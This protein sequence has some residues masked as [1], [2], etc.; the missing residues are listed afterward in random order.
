MKDPFPV[1]SHD[2]WRARVEA[3]LGGEDFERTLVTH[4]LEGL[5][6]QPLYSGESPTS[7]RTKLVDG[8]GFP[9]LWPFTRG[10]RAVPRG[11]R[12]WRISQLEDDPDPDGLRESIGADLWGGADAVW[13]R[14]DR[15]A[16]LGLDGDSEKAAEHTGWNGA[17]LYSAADLEAALAGADLAG[18]ALTFD[19]GANA[20]PAAALAVAAL[21]ASG[22][23]PEDL[24]LALGA[25]PLGALARD[26]EIPGPLPSLTEE[27]AVL[28]A[29]CH[30]RLPRSSAV[31]VSTLPYHDAGAD[32]VQE[33]AYALA[34]GVHYLRSLEAT[35]LELGRACDQVVF[36]FAVGRHLFV[37]IAKL[38]AARLLWA[39]VARACGLEQPSP[40][41]IHATTSQRTL[42]CRDPWNNVVRV[43]TQVFAAIA[44]G[45]DSITSS[46]FDRALGRPGADSRRLARN[47]QLILAEEAHLGRVLDPAGGSFYIEWLTEELARSA[48]SLFKEIERRGGMAESL[49]SGIIAE[50]VEESWRRRRERVREGV[51]PITGVTDFTP[52]D[53]RELP[54]QSDWRRPEVVAA[55]VRRTGEYRRTRGPLDIELPADGVER[56]ET[57][58]AAASRGATLGELSAALERSGEPAR[59][60]RF[61][62]RRDSEPFEDA[63]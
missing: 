20:L 46:G 44:G 36:R 23:A 35:G 54:V 61:P 41:R 15:A 48:W 50:Q 2:E 55:A 45:A 5:A 6:I 59:M 62:L 34:T 63:S 42:T 53:E 28:A 32:T 17:T 29:Y 11:Q 7:S 13:L 33:L 25:D 30:Q 57:C 47:T 56:V 52:A 49:A 19:A 38:R 3:E 26:G 43:T 51:D 40:A 12:S 9:G 24:E 1:V 4:T 31:G 37:E 14:F 58:I 60:P 18:V 8:S 39:R 27:M 22:Q 16:R 21:A 10:A